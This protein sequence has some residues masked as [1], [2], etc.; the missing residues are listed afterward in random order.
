MANRTSPL[1]SLGHNPEPFELNLDGY[2]GEPLRCTQVVRAIPGKRLVCRAQW[3]DQGVFAKLYLGSGRH[4]YW[5]REVAGLEA[6]AHHGIACPAL[7]HRGPVNAGEALVVL[8]EPIVSAQTLAT[9][10]EQARTDEE[11]LHILGEMM[12]VSARLHAQGLEQQDPHLE[13]FVRTPRGLHVLDGGAVK[14]HRRPL[15]VDLSLSNLGLLLAKLL[16]EYDRWAPAALGGYCAARA[17]SED[18]LA[19]RLARQIL[20]HRRKRR[21]RFLAKIFRECSACVCRQGLRR[22]TVYRRD[23]GSP[24]LKRLLADPDASLHQPGARRLK[25]GNTCTVWSI[26]L[27][28]KTLAIKRY[29]R[30]NLLHGLNR[31][32]RASR[33]AIS[34]RNAHRLEFYAIP[35]PSPVALVEERMGPL[36]GRAY[37]ITEVVNGENALERFAP[38]RDQSPEGAFD[39]DA[40]CRLIARLATLGI[41]HGDMK[42]SN[43]I[44]GPDGPTVLDLDA[45]R[46][47]DWRAP[48]AREHRRDIRRFQANWHDRP[49]LQRRFAQSLVD[50]GLEVDTSVITA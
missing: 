45:L 25:D 6:L 37:F 16:P 22:F 35:T 44:F 31:A 5:R 32:W 18:G 12:E 13:N 11:R 26:P 27:D 39:M 4:R 3:R 19:P 33:A 41:T 40:L 23:C 43:F 30:K 20:S 28:G 9:V 47:H 42:G 10:W 15:S 34:W 2:P 36:R 17:W 14:R 49:D 1:T 29:N 50:N 21:D 46:E 38:D 8:L 7:I 48:F 24:A